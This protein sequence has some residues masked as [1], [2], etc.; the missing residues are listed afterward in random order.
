MWSDPDPRAHARHPRT[1]VGRSKS[2]FVSSFALRPSPL[3]NLSPSPSL[4]FSL[5]AALLC[6]SCTPTA[7]LPPTVGRQFSL[8]ESDGQV[9]RHSNPSRMRRKR[10][11]R[12]VFWCSRKPLPLASL[13]RSKK[14]LKTALSRRLSLFYFRPASLGDRLL[15]FGKLAAAVLPPSSSSSSS[16]D[17]LR[18]RAGP[19]SSVA[20]LAQS[21]MAATASFP[22]LPPSASPA[23]R[24]CRRCLPIPTPLTRPGQSQGERERACRVRTAC[25][26]QGAPSAPPPNPLLM[27]ASRLRG[28]RR[29]RG[30]SAA[31]PT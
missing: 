19:M 21:L 2:S 16:T 25:R 10:S 24:R 13:L 5:V 6:S 11:Q 14:C 15:Y 7:P 20:S 26:S 27:L 22:S 18:H 3:L 8:S 17:D 30:V 1:H 9:I 28:G 12:E 29:D 31:P 23:R 4:S